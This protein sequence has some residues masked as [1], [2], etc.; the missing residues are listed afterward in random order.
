MELYR[1]VFY[2]TSFKTAEY[3]IRLQVII[4]ELINVGWLFVKTS[5]S[6]ISQ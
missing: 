4:Q 3:K 6:I 1:Q 2:K 5:L